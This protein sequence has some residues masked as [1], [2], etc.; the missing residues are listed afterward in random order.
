MF[1]LVRQSVPTAL[2]LAS[3]LAVA[4]SAWGVPVDASSVKACGNAC[5]G[6]EGC[7]SQCFCVVHN[8]CEDEDDCQNQPCNEDQG[9]QC[10]DQ[11]QCIDLPAGMCE[12][13]LN[14]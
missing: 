2:L 1:R 12:E 14:R 11:C 5:N 4:I 13:D 7:T 10:G 9:A 3:A 8:Y 6:G